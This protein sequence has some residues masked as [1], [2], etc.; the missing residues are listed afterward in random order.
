MAE[1]P[2]PVIPPLVSQ[3]VPSTTLLGNTWNTVILTSAK[4]MLVVHFYRA[5]LELPLRESKIIVSLLEVIIEMIPSLEREHAAKGEKFPS[6]GE[7]V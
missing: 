7:Q 4:E 6:I 1:A 3:V 5:L 2:R